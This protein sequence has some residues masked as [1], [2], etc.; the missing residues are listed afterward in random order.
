MWWNVY[1]ALYS[2]FPAEY[3]SE[4]ILKSVK[5]WQSYC[6]NLGASFFLEHGVYIYI[7]VNWSPTLVVIIGCGQLTSTRVSYLGRTP[8]SATGASLSLNHWSTVL[9]HFASGTLTARHWTY[10]ISA[11]TKTHQ[12]T[13]VY[14]DFCFNYAIQIFFFCYY[15]IQSNRLIGWCFF[16]IEHIGLNI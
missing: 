12:L 5:I 16:N 9:E 15:Y 1:T 8:S 6:Q 4:R 14:S 10:H 2:K 7:S 3:G 11:A 13:Q